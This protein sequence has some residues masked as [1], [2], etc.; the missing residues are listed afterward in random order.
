MAQLDEREVPL[1]AQRSEAF[2]EVLQDFAQQAARAG[3]TP[4]PPVQLGS[5]PDEWLVQS[6]DVGSNDQITKLTFKDEADQSVFL[7]LTAQQLRQWLSIV[8]AAWVK[9]EWHAGIWPAWVLS[10]VTPSAQQAVVLH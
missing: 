2:A 1:A 9:A 6:V 7:V 3:L 4:Q 10:A 8:H 5:N